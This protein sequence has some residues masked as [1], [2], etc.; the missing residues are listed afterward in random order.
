ME[1]NSEIQNG[2]ASWGSVQVVHLE[3]NLK[4]AL[5]AIHM[6]VLHFFKLSVDDYIYKINNNSIYVWA[7]LLTVTLQ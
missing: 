4:T 6:F 1:Q 7:L 5:C 3:I 2:S